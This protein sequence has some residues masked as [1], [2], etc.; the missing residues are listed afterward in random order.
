MNDLIPDARQLLQQSGQPV[1]LFT[2]SWCSF[3]H[4]AKQLMRDLK[5][6][7]AVIELDTGVYKT[8]DIHNRLR[9]DLKQMTGSNT[10]PQI[11]VGTTPV[12]GY[13]DAQ[14]ALRNGQLKKLL[15]EHNIH[16]P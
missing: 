11:F 13:T 10:L 4:A 12:G 8:A 16:L 3:C 14:A 15:A 9:Q 1:T 2:L 6:P 7:H 5:V